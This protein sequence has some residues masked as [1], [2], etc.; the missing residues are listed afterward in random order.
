MGV[1]DDDR[2][3]KPTMSEKYIVTESNASAMTG[4]P[5]INVS[6]TDLI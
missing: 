2:A 4:S 6:A 5:R 1:L 3:V